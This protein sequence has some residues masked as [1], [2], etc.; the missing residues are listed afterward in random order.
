MGLWLIKSFDTA[1]RNNTAIIGLHDYI[2]M[3]EW[4]NEDILTAI[5]ESFCFALFDLTDLPAIIGRVCPSIA[6]K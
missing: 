5:I 4:S 6:Y 2:S 3:N 1:L